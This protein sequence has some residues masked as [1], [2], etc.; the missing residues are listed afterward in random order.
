MP[1][2]IKIP[3][4][5]QQTYVKGRNVVQYVTSFLSQDNM[6]L[7]SPFIYEQHSFLLRTIMK[8]DLLEAIDH[9]GQ[10]LNLDLSYFRHVPRRLGWAFTLFRILGL[11]YLFIDGMTHDDYLYIRDNAYNNHTGSK[12]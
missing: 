11:E 3:P 8:K 4:Y 10:F 6:I 5:I 2:S 9:V 12:R 7:F 1:L